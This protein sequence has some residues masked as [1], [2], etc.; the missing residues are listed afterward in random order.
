M[1]RSNPLKALGSH[2]NLVTWRKGA[3]TQSEKPR[4]CVPL[5]LKNGPQL[6]VRLPRSARQQSS[7]C[8]A[9]GVAR[10]LRLTDLAPCLENLSSFIDR[11]RSVYG[12]VTIWWACCGR[13]VRAGT[14]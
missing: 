2:V 9:A 1:V 11:R 5:R 12:N 3:G 10:A 14:R 13:M 6:N 8:S 4:N 7:D